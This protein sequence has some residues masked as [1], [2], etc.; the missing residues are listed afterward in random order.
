MIRKARQRGRLHSQ[1]NVKVG[2]GQLQYRKG[3][4]N[5]QS[6]AAPLIARALVAARPRH[7]QQLIMKRSIQAFNGSLAGLVLAD[8]KRVSSGR[9]H[10]CV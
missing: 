7:L 6:L 3:A 9:P 8:P 1:Q 2:H 5:D 4:S 10:T